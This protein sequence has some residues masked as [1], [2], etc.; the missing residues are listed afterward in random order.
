MWEDWKH[1]EI[2][3]NSRPFQTV[4][5]S[6]QASGEIKQRPHEGVE[7]LCLRGFR[8]IWF[9]CFQIWL[10]FSFSFVFTISPEEKSNSKQ[11]FTE[12]QCFLN[13]ETQPSMWL[14]TKQFRNH[15]FYFIDFFILRYEAYFHHR[16]Q[17]KTSNCVIKLKIRTLF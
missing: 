3:L 5:E 17:N 1:T 14:F 11:A 8:E 10:S 13:V 4:C 9:R 15:L 6:Y 12:I 7:L 16:T 2:T